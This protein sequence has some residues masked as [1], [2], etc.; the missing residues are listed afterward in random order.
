MDEG[1]DFGCSCLSFGAWTIG[2]EIDGQHVTAAETH[3]FFL[4]ENFRRVEGIATGGIVERA[5]HRMGYFFICII[6]EVADA[7]NYGKIG[8][9]APHKSSD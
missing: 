1:W 4:A 9:K 8:L 5:D 6:R 3:R 2:A 7:W